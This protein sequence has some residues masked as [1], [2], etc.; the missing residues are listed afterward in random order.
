MN[1]KKLKKI[2]RE[3]LDNL[4]KMDRKMGKKKTLSTKEAIYQSFNY[5]RIISLEFV[6]ALMFPYPQ[7]K[8]LK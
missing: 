8:D 1:K 2:L 3:N 4:W 7:F 5:G 6:F